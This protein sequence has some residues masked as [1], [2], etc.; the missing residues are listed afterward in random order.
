MDLVI[1]C[2]ERGRPVTECPQSTDGDLDEFKLDQANGSKTRRAEISG[3]LFHEFEQVVSSGLAD[4][5]VES[6]RDSGPG[7]PVCVPPRRQ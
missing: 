7:L 6:V 1:V 3:E 2:F 5:D 4:D